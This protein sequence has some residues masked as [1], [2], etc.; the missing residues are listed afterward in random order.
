MPQPVSQILISAMPSLADRSSVMKPPA[1]VNLIALSSRFATMR[2]IFILSAEIRLLRQVQ[3]E[4][5][6]LF[7]R[8]ELVKIISLF[9]KFIE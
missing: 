4:R 7:F 9:Q 1:G 8:K 5:L 6:P 3:T 2:C